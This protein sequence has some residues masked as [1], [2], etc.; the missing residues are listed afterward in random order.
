MKDL[1]YLL[2]YI[3]PACFFSGL[4]FLGWASWLTLIFGYL[5]VPIVDQIGPVS[6]ENFSPSE[7]ESRLTNLFFDW[8]LYLN[9][10]IVYFSVAASIY[11]F[12]TQSLSTFEIIGT[13]GSLGFVLGAMG[14]NVGHELGHRSTKFEQNLSK[15]LYI[16]SHYIHFFIEHNKGHH[17]NVATPIDP[18]T[19][20][21]GQMLYTFWIQSVIG[22]YRSAWN[23]ENSRLQADGQSVLSWNNQM[24]RFTLYQV[25]YWVFIF[26]V[27]TPL[28]AAY[29]MIA[30]VVSFL[31]LETINYIEHYGLQRKLLPS[32]RYERVQSHHSWNANYPFGR[33]LLYELTRHSDHHFIA[34][35]KYQILDH[36][37]AAP[38]LPM[39]Y[40]ASMMASF[41]PPLWY[42]IMDQRVPEPS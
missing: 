32:G 42:R 3:T 14:I 23:I 26:Y 12:S 31:L 4:Y 19:A 41:I 37:D 15:L 2:A 40:P 28:I 1:K 18:A 6:E 8:L 13:I 39:G 30:G 35:K 17:K 29:I 33:I 16:P 5:I 10:P 21:K 24:I 22:A 25:G 20:R 34:S 38:E 36:H 7:K 9:L 27:T 11:I